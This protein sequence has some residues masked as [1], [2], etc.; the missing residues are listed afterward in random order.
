MPLP[1]AHLCFKESLVHLPS[2][3]QADHPT[4]CLARVDAPSL[5]PEHDPSD[6]FA[7]AIARKHSYQSDSPRPLMMSGEG[8]SPLPPQPAHWALPGRCHRLSAPHRLGRRHRLLWRHEGGSSWGVEAPTILWAMHFPCTGS[9]PSMHEVCADAPLRKIVPPICLVLL[10][11]ITSPLT[12][13]L[14]L[15]RPTVAP[16]CC[17]PCRLACTVPRLGLPPTGPAP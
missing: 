8:N 5:R 1:A 2:K 4:T 17:R 7:Q 12:C 11:E 3:V 10:V 13:R 15:L 9:I 14:A 6:S 16:S